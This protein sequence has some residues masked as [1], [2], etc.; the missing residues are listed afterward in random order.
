MAFMN[1]FVCDD[2]SAAMKSILK[3]RTISTLWL[4]LFLKSIEYSTISLFVYE[5]KMYKNDTNLV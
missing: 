2:T 4:P 3:V 5:L 1:S